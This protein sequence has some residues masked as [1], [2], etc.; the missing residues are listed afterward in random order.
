MRLSPVVR[1][2][3]FGSVL[4]WGGFLLVAAILGK[5]FAVAYVAIFYLVYAVRPE[6]HQFIERI[7]VGREKK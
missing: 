5:W 6:L 7:S 3:I 4:S 2:V 1:Y